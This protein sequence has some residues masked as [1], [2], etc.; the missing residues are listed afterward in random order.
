MRRRNSAMRRR[1]SAMRMRNSAMRILKW[2]KKKAS[3]L[4]MN[5]IKSVIKYLQ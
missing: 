4:R 5:M 1:N 2:N 3:L